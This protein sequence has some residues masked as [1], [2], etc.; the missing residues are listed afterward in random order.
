M[1]LQLEEKKQGL[2]EA[3]KKKQASQSGVADAWRLKGSRS[4]KNIRS[5]ETCR[6]CK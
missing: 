2:F 1:Y 3:L 4:Q 5:I 6:L